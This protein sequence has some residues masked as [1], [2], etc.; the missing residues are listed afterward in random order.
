MPSTPQDLLQGVYWSFAE[1][2]PADAHAL[3]E[4]ARAYAAAIEVPDPFL[5]LAAT[6]PLAD[7]RLRY[8]YGVRDDSGEWDEQDAE[9]R[10]TA[11]DGHLTG[12]QL[13][14]ELH[15]ACAPTVGEDDHHFFEGLALEDAGGDGLP[16]LYDVQLGS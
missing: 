15:A 8:T 11:A 2:V 3:I 5:T 4:A 1:P 10:V 6:L 9:L 13:L 14:W 16:P 12:A 7:V